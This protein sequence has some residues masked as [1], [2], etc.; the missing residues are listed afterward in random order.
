MKPQ[1]R[2]LRLRRTTIL[3]LAPDQARL[4]AGGGKRVITGDGNTDE[5]NCTCTCAINTCG[6]VSCIN[7][8]CFGGDCFTF[9]C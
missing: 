8:A 6:I 4:A 1:D 3:E 7:T 9:P 2:K 5:D